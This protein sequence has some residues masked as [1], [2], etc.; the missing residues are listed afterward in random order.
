MVPAILQSLGIVAAIIFIDLT[1]SGDNALVIG[2][3]ASRLHGSR[4]RMALVVGGGLAII[5]RI[6][7]TIFAALILQLHYVKAAGGVIVLIISILL[8]RDIYQ[9]DTAEE[10]QQKAQT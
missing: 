9:G 1:L 5:L 7:L 8:L 10:N 2:A 6:T 3:A 4:R